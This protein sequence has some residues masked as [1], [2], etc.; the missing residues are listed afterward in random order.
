MNFINTTSTF[1]NG[2]IKHVL[3]P[4]PQQPPIP[5]GGRPVTHKNVRR[6][7]SAGP[8]HNSHVLRN[9]SSSNFNNKRPKYKHFE[10][11]SL[12]NLNNPQCKKMTKFKVPQNTYNTILE[13]LRPK[14]NSI[15]TYE[16]LQRSQAVSTKKVFS[17]V[18]SATIRNSFRN[19]SLLMIKPNKQAKMKTI[20]QTP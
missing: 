13:G 9:I 10:K 16:S 19:S 15:M 3:V 8:G 5:F 1:D 20:D 4:Q 12:N 2:P 14:S 18:T 17:G 6:L 7:M 11:T